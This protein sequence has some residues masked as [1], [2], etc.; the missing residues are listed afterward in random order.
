MSTSRDIPCEIR[1]FHKV[2]EKLSYY[3]HDAG[4][5]LDTFLEW[6]MWGFC[7]DGSLHWNSGK[8]FAEDERPVFYELFQQW[9]L[10]MN[11]KLTDDKMWFDMFGTYYENYVAGKSRRDSKGQFF[12][13]EHI[14]DLM[15][16]LQGDGT[17]RTGQTA[18]DPCCGSG[19]FLLSFHT[20]NPGNYLIAEDIDRT[21]CMM[22]VCN[23]IIHGAVGEVVHHNSLAPDSWFTG[24]IVNEH[25]NNPLH[26]H[27]GVP[28]VRKLSK[29]N[30]LVMNFWKQRAEEVARQRMMS[31]IAETV[32]VPQN[33]PNTQ[34]H[35][36]KIF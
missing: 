18:S 13:P 9:A 20:N 6:V 22:T 5:V 24:W 1:P 12:T 10:L 35:Q 32:I 2:F 25:L 15:V 3:K 23:F 33:R 30:S 17:A 19:R 16:K 26:K 34:Y 28:H 4:E 8:R 29:E 21:C 11:A 27:F 14:C 7:P 36:L 31:D